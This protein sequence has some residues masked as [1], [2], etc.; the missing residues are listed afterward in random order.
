MVALEELD[1]ARSI[2]KCFHCGIEQGFERGQHVLLAEQCQL[3]WGRRWRGLRE[4]RL[5]GECLQPCGNRSGS[6]LSHTTIL[7]GSQGS[8]GMVGSASLDITEQKFLKNKKIGSGSFQHQHASRCDLPPPLPPP[9][10][11]SRPS[12]LVSEHSHTWKLVSTHWLKLRDAR[13]TRT[14][15]HKL[16]CDIYCPCQCDTYC[17]CVSGYVNY[18]IHL[19]MLLGR[20]VDCIVIRVNN[21]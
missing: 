5:G 9:L 11:K 14:H 1:D 18:C 19:S 17:Q 4:V 16:S 10:G 7:H 3:R 15:R 2:G 8:V 21:P 20:H 12:I 6:L 13:D